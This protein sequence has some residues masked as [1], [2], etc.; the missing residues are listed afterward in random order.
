MT[1]LPITWRR[2][3]QVPCVAGGMVLEGGSIDVNGAGDL[4]TT[5]S[6]LLN[7]NRNP[8]FS[9]EEIEGR[10]QAMLGVHQILWLGEGI[11]G[12][13]TD[14][15]VDD[16]TRFVGPSTVVSVVEEDPSDTNYQPLQDNLE[17]LQT[18][19]TVSGDRLRVE[20]L[21]MPEPIF[22]GEQRLPASYAN[23]YIANR[24]VLVPQFRQANDEIARSTLQRLFP[25][26][27]IIGLDCVDVVAGL[28]AIHCLTQQVPAA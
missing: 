4:L 25:E 7:P 10:L 1:P 6:C 24:K 9:R 19:Q 14:G 3:L 21:P 12:D 16:L 2:I 13:D 28:G 26:R 5:E 8:H 23:F 11:V 17:R 27:H 18:M 22:H 20:T 15:H